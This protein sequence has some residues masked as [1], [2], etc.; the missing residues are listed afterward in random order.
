M[1]SR[2]E[3]AIQRALVD[4]LVKKYPQLVTQATLNENSRHNIDMGLSVG[5]TDLLIFLRKDDIC[6]IFF[7]ELKT[8]AKASRLRDSQV[9]WYRDIYVPKLQASNTH[10]A[11]SKGFT[12]AKLAVDSF[13]S[14]VYSTNA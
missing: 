6:H 9:E 13:F 3:S 4:W 5:I 14:T 12:E 8:K 7:H 1:T 11:V 10:Y 2:V